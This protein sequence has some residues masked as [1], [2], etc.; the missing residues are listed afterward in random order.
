MGVNM[1]PHKVPDFAFSV[2]VC[3]CYLS[4][5][6]INTMTKSNWGGKDYLLLQLVVVI[7]GQEPGGRRKQ[8]L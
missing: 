4:I 6:V 3:L 5:A 2:A 1:N 8:K 7:Q